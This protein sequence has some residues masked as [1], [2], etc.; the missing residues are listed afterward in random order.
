[1][2]RAHVHAAEGPLPPSE[3]SAV[4]SIGDGGALRFFA[5]GARCGAGRAAAE[6]GVGRRGLGA[7]GFS[8]YWL[9]WL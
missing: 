6:G 5:A 9:S 7:G 8:A 3:S 1:M 4:R 2:Q